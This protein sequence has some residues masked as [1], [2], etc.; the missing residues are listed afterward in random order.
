MDPYWS[1]ANPRLVNVHQ[2]II[3]YLEPLLTEYREWF[4]AANDGISQSNAKIEGLTKRRKLCN[5]I[6][7]RIDKR[8]RQIDELNAQSRADQSSTDPQQQSATTI[9]VT[10]IESISP[11]YDNQ[12]DVIIPSAKLRNAPACDLSS[13]VELMLGR[14]NK[15]RTDLA[16]TTSSTTM[17]SYGIDHDTG[18]LS[19]L[20]EIAKATHT[21]V[22]ICEEQTDG[23]HIVCRFVCNK[24]KT[25]WP[26]QRIQT[27]TQ[28]DLFDTMAD[29][30]GCSRREIFDYCPE[31]APCTINE[32]RRGKTKT[33]YV[34]TV[35]RAL[36]SLGGYYLIV[37]DKAYNV[38]CNIVQASDEGDENGEVGTQK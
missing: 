14:V 5:S 19:T 11:A 26:D 33:H 25:P 37:V 1:Y 15:T 30:L 2:A 34:K 3:E 13:A 17:Y 27:T 21:A 18:Y 6:I 20:L 29:Y 4:Q 32:V 9:T 24:G 38:V 7:E 36:A 31:V 28:V 22:M 35:L 16:K 10:Q 12:H 8:N 23:E